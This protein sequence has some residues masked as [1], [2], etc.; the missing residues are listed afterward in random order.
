MADQHVFND[1]LVVSR[2]WVGV[3]TTSD[4]DSNPPTVQITTPGALTSRT[5]PVLFEVVD[6]SP[7]SL[8]VVAAR[9]PDLR[10]TELIYVGASFYTPYGSSSREGNSFTVQR[11][12]GWPSGFDL[13]VSAVD[14][15]GNAV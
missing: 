6:D 11:D 9:Y 5:D 4:K 12:G 3:T 10:R 2:R 8:V 7:L 13:I 14:E 1:P 15:H